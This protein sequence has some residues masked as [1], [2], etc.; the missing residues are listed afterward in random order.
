[1]TAEQHPAAVT[2]AA[3]RSD[4]VPGVFLQ[5]EL[6]LDVH[7]T[8]AEGPVWDARRGLLWW[9][10][11][12]E[13][14][15]HAF[16]PVRAQD[17]RFRAG[18]PVGALTLRGDGSLLLAMQDSFATLDPASGRVETILALPPEPHPRRANDGKCDP[19]GRFLV[20]R[21]A[22]DESEGCGDLY[23]LDA[24]RCVTRLLDNLTIPN[25][26]AWR[27][28]GRELYF[29]DSPRRQVTAYPYDV[30]TGTLGLGRALVRFEGDAVPDGMTTDA[31]GCL[32]VAL[33]GGGR[34]LCV[35]PGGEILATVGLPVSQV[36]S[37]TFGGPGLDEL[38]ITTAREG[39]GPDDDAREPLAGCLF[40]V[41]PGVRGHL[42]VPFAG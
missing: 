1:M 9:T 30:V 16:D 29:I 38:Y 34:V 40:R 7:A 18:G 26:L 11:I 31:D 17:A 15:V 2:A 20:G 4:L 41:R 3:G 25:G 8:L 33:W 10:D 36:S 6:V 12:P 42:P 21:M 24:D 35:S 22:L 32:W 23:R 27:A 19:R 37:C 39:F 13:G 5:A 28:D 14:S